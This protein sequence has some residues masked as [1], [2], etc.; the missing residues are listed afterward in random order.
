MGLVNYSVP[1]ARLREEVETLAKELLDKN[2]V[3]LRAA[4][5]GFRNCRN[6]DTDGAL[7]Y[8]Y[9][10][11]E[12]S[13]FLDKEKGRQQGLRQFLDDKTIRPGLQSYSRS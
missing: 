2:P 9:A 10:K 3:V 7:D 12:Q 6:M 13:Q 1:L 8:L 5:I 4:K 11:L